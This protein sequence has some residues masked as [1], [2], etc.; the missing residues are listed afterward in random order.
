MPFRHFIVPRI[1]TCGLMCKMSNIALPLSWYY[2]LAARWT[3]ILFIFIG[4]SGMNSLAFTIYSILHSVFLFTSLLLFK[5]VGIY[6]GRGLP[7]CFIILPTFSNVKRIREIALKITALTN[8]R[9]G[10][11]ICY[12]VRDPKGSPEEIRHK[13]SIPDSLRIN[14]TRGYTRRSSSSRDAPGYA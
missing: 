5:L 10:G 8:Y 13:I 14:R 4:N 9:S 6:A 3:K 12:T 11:F 7:V 1:T 2:F